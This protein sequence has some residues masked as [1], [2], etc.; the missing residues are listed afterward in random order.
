MVALHQDVFLFHDARR[1]FFGLLPIGLAYHLGYSLL[2]A[3][4]MALL[5]R[6]AWPAD[7]E[8]DAAPDAAPGTPADELD[9]KSVKKPNRG[10]S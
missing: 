4:V 10:I 9:E 3:A 5:V 8:D 2:S 6:Y 1:V 7:L